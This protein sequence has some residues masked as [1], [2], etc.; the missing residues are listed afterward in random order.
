MKTRMLIIG[1]IFGVFVLGAVGG[2]QLADWNGR[3]TVIREV[4]EVVIRTDDA[5]KRVA[6]RAEGMVVGLESRNAEGHVIVGS[7][8]AAT[9][10]GFIF[11]L[12]SAVP[13]GYTTRVY[14][15]EGGNPIVAEVLKRDFKR[16]L[17][18]LKID[19]RNLQT[20]GFA[21]E[22]SVKVGAPVVLVAKTLEEGLLIT[23][24]NQ[25]TVRTKFGE[26]IRTNIFDKASLGGSPL[27]NLEGNIVGLSVFE[28]S[29]RLV[30]I[31]TSVLRAF[32]GF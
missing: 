15:K 26:A 17:A 11:T 27:L 24:V 6:E 1:I 7:G 2:T 14:L 32:S 13:Q 19:E 3:A 10:D 16:D 31:P 8:F 20:T 23:I 18:V 25:G 4:T 29:G 30:A 12:A 5:A 28:P 21:S 22:D 9:S